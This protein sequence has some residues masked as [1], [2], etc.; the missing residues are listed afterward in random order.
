MQS[1]ESVKV[2][3]SASISPVRERFSNQQAVLRIAAA[4]GT[5]AQPTKKFSGAHHYFAEARLDQV[6][7]SVQ[8]QGARCLPTK[9]HGL[10]CKPVLFLEFHLIRLMFKSPATSSF[11]QVA[12][13]VEAAMHD[14]TLLAE[15]FTEVRIPA[16]V[17]IGLAV[18]F[19][20]WRAFYP[21]FLPQTCTM[22]S[23]SWSVRLMVQCLCQV[24]VLTSGKLATVL[25]L[26]LLIA[27]LG[28]RSE[29][30]SCQ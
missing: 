17:G 6:A 10:P 20:A 27:D 21:V 7:N 19:Q 11:W 14:C 5:D 25:S 22:H 2:Q 15:S 28:R 12:L 26:G 24:F 13:Y 16:C 1:V 9:G 18:F 3:F 8:A 4:G 23:C 30:P 29:R